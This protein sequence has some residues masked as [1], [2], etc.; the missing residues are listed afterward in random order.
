MIIYLKNVTFGW[1]IV[2]EDPSSDSHYAVGPVHNSAKEARD[3][4]K[5][6]I[7]RIAAPERKEL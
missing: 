1:Q 6:N 2:I 4:Q 5:E 3:W 7:R